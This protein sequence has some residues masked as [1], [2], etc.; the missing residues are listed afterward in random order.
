MF[1]LGPIGFLE[2]L[3]FKEKHEISKMLLGWMEDI[4]IP[5]WK[6]DIQLNEL[7]AGVSLV[8]FLIL[9]Y[10]LLKDD[11]GVMEKIMQEYSFTLGVFMYSFKENVHNS[12]YLVSADT[13]SENFLRFAEG[14]NISGSWFNM[15]VLYG[16]SFL[17]KF[18]NVTAPLKMTSKEYKMRIKNGRHQI[19]VSEHQAIRDL[20]NE[21]KIYLEGLNANALRGEELKRNQ[22]LYAM[23][24]FLSDV[25]AHSPSIVS[26]YDYFQS[27]YN[28]LINV[29]SLS[30]QDIEKKLR[31]SPEII[32]F[33]RAILQKKYLNGAYNLGVVVDATS[34]TG[35]GYIY[36]AVPLKENDKFAMIVFKGSLAHQSDKVEIIAESRKMIKK[37]NSSNSAKKLFG[38]R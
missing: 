17:R 1:Y 5:I 12:A 8:G 35:E 27:N 29:S 22:F 20:T 15:E 32:V 11:K 10:W 3:L 34:S 25:Y 13:H 16:H 38:L 36:V 2:T 24:T 30:N 9:S 26:L 19:T 21:L 6:V 18:E 23:L 31:K 14:V 37:I 7:V 33:S 28:V 4:I